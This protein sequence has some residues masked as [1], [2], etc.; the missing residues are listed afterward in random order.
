MTGH[1]FA[2]PTDEASFNFE[3]ELKIRKKIERHTSWNYEFDKNGDK[4]GYDLVVTG[5]DDT[6]TDPQDK[7]LLG[8]VELERATA[9]TWDY[10][11][12]PSSWNFFSFLTRKVREWNSDEKKWDGIKENYDKT[13]YVRFN[14]AMT[15]CVAVPIEVI[16]R[17]GF[18]TKK[19]QGTYNESFLAL[20]RDNP[21]LSKGIISSIQQIDS[22]LQARTPKQSNLDHWKP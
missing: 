6:P 5:W 4:Y 13:I 14:H 7:Q 17:Q 20:D 21:N 10:G 11:K 2:V 1:D 8:F 12:P 19:S 3:D 22:Y 15:D 18:E 9:N 16:F